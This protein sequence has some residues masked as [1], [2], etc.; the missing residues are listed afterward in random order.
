[1]FSK[2]ARAIVWANG[3]RPFAETKGQIKKTLIST[4]WRSIECSNVLQ[5]TPNGI[6]YLS[7]QL[8]AIAIPQ[9]ATKGCTKL[10]KTY[11]YPDY[12]ATKSSN[13][14]FTKDQKP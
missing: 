7:V 3:F 14:K 9:S 5:I 12:C 6:Y 10:H 8:C 13:P 4:I 1:V 11:P 2:S